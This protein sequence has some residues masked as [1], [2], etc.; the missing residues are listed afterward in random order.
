MMRKAESKLLKELGRAPLPG[1]I[2]SALN[3]DEERIV[4]MFAWDGNHPTSLDK[5]VGDDGDAGSV[6]GDF[7]VN[8]NLV[9]SERLAEGRQELLLVKEKVDAVLAQVCA[10]SER[11]GKMV[12]MRY[13][14]DDGY[15]RRTLDAVAEVFGVTRERIRQIV[16]ARLSQVR[17]EGIRSNEMVTWLVNAVNQL[18]DLAD[19]TPYQDGGID[20]ALGE[21]RPI[22]T[23]SPPRPT[24]QAPTDSAQSPPGLEHI[25]R[26][27]AL[28]PE[29]T[30]ERNQDLFRRFYGLNGDWIPRKAEAVAT[31]AGVSTSLV[32]MNNV[33]I[34]KQ[35]YKRGVS[36]KLDG[37]WLK[38]TV[39]ELHLWQQCSGERLALGGKTLPDTPIVA[40]PESP[41]SGHVP[42]VRSP[43]RKANALHLLALIEELKAFITKVNSLP[44]RER[45]IAKDIIIGALE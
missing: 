22:R 41:A 2:A 6:L 20:M 25:E 23:E 24:K 29:V 1:E 30:S 39:K 7:I 45:E 9:S 32:T 26:I 4:Q 8:M 15:R 5:P 21:R 44:M 34:W 17:I 36:S 40:S 11:D 10:I 38:R 37:R 31:G 16:D 19:T 27:H 13:G 3:C 18:Q 12:A 35:L 14:L 28:L 43:E 33:T 42:Q